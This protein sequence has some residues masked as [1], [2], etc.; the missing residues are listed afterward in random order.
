MKVTDFDDF[1]FKLTKGNKKNINPKW[2][3]VDNGCGDDPD[4]PD[5]PGNGGGKSI[6]IN[7]ITPSKGPVA[8]GG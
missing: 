3:K 1:P 8:G 5:D 2:F 4:D 7:S 6:T